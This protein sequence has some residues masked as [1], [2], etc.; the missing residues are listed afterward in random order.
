MVSK[1]IGRNVIALAAGSVL[2]SAAPNPPF[3]YDGV[4]EASAA[5]VVDR[6]RFVV[7]SDD[8][9]RL[10][11][12]ARGAA[13]PVS[14]FPHPG[15]T[16]IEAAARIG[17]TIFWLTS[18]SLNSSGEDKAKR[19]ALFA[20]KVLPNGTLAAAGTDYHALRAELAAALGVPEKIEQGGQIVG[21]LA[22]QLNIEGLAAAPDGRL[23]I[24]LRGPLAAGKA[25]VV[26][27]E[28]PFTLVGLPP[29]PPSGSPNPK[30]FRLNLGGRGIRSLE[31]VGSG[32]R[33][34]LI[35]AGPVA[36]TGLAPRL[37][38]WDGVHQPTP[39]PA[40]VFG[41][42]KPEALIVW[43]VYRGQILGDNDDQ[44]SEDS[45]TPPRRF[46]SLDVSF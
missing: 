36:D 4:C 21:G 20:T 26:R 16:D 37:Y 23:L 18:H 34:F 29:H 7:A 3:Y 44:C 24:G 46:P 38:W 1:R 27:I 9:D 41:Q 10:T 28:D 5:A 33:T 31:R 13:G 43:T 6:R 40:L 35:V 15:V 30:V 32:S 17:D 2:L 39:G 19:K 42:V 8:L 45:P 22:A 11:V 14:I 12:Y 25:Q